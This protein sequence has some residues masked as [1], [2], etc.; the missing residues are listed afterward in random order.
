MLTVR[1]AALRRLQNVQISKA[2]ARP[3]R[4]FAVTATQHAKPRSS[5]DRAGGRAGGRR[6]QQPFGKLEDKQGGRPSG[7]RS[8]RPASSPQPVPVKLRPGSLPGVIS[9]RLDE[10]VDSQRV[11]TRLEAFGFGAADATGLLHNWRETVQEDLAAMDK[12]DDGFLDR[13]SAMGWD[14]Q[15]L[16]LAYESGEWSSV[17]EAAFLRHFLTYAAAKGSEH[18]RL[19]I[20]ALL[21]ATDISNYAARH[22]NARTVN[23]QFHLH[24]GPTNSGKT[25]NALK[26]LAKS[27]TGVYAGPLRLLAHEVWERLNLGSVGGLD[28]RP[29]PCSLITGEERRIVQDGQDMISCTVEM[30]PLFGHSSGNPWDVVVIDEIQM[31]GDAQRGG[32]WT[33]AVMGANAKEIH[34]C[35]DETTADLLK[36][37]I[38]TFKGDTL[39]V[40]RYERLTPLSVADE[41]L[42]G[43]WNNIQPGDCVVTFSRNNVFAAKK[44]IEG[45]VGKKCAVVYGALPPETRAEQARDFNEEAGRAEIMVA[46]DAVGMG[47]N[48]KIGRIVFES[49][50]KFDGKQ[51]VPL[52]LSQVKQIAGRAGRFG[53]QRKG[54][55]ED[56]SSPDEVAHPGGVVTTLHE[57]DLPLL[58][59][60]M[61]LSLPSVSRAVIEPPSGALAGLAPL[62]PAQTSFNELMGHFEAL[63]KLPPLTVLASLSHRAPLAEIVGKYRD[64]LTLSECVQ[65][66]VAPVN[67]RDAKVA[68]IFESILKSY[69][70]EMNVRLEPTL[71]PTTL[72][73]TLKTVEETLAALPPLPP[74]LGIYRPYLVPPITVAAIPLL[75]S[76][77]KA[78]VLY[79][80]LSFRFELA[81]PDRDLAAKYKERTEKALEICLERMPGVRQKKR[82]ERTGEMD[83]EHALYRRKYVD[84]HGLVKP[85]IEWVAAE[86]AS[87]NRKREQWGQVE[88]RDIN[89]KDYQRMQE[90][91]RR[92]GTGG[93]EDEPASFGIASKPTYTPAD[94]PQ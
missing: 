20:N 49:L 22:L 29:R 18:M 12:D 31:L 74:H 42:N 15:T 65:F 69:S 41:S 68:A 32:A 81:F 36:S 62:L 79:I 19:H 53:Q 58:R 64:V 57:A 60:M 43:D 1:Q 45:T 26:A 75:E 17:F 59:A 23:R 50:T 92:P 56:E 51:E 30:L 10:W 90:M 54:E 55:G 84:K 6:Q 16:T 40:H 3:A 77:H 35:G 63:A 76:L 13:M 70:E 33:A 7:F 44:A 27:P 38:G 85:E 83:R 71:A 72:I 93:E 2:A 47:L 46:S 21:Q 14:A 52:S 11:K 82:E 24:M 4:S 66:G 28:G 5:G 73:K 39:T 61:P 80:W 37:I 8:Q 91:E 87:R 34:L 89:S 25:Y 86:L 78:L 9:G 48:L 88:W 67:W 94:Q